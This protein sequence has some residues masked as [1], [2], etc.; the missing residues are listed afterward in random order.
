MTVGSMVLL[1]LAALVG[2]A[3]NSVAGGGSFVSFPSLVVS[4]VPLVT[5]N[6]T[7][8]VALWPGSASSVGAYRRE[9][10]QHSRGFVIVMG[11][12]SLVGGLL[13]A[14]LLLRT[15]QSTFANL[16]P[17]LLLLATVLFAF[18]GRIAEQLRTRGLIGGKPS[19]VGLGLILIFQFV[20]AV[21]GGY[22][23]GGIGILMLAALELIGIDNIHQ[24]NALK[25]VLATCT[26]GVAV[27][28]FVVAGI[29]AWPQA[30]V[31]IVA[32]MIGGYGCASFARRL[33][34]LFV[35]AFVIV[36]AVSMTLYFF[37]RAYLVAA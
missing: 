37:A 1:F 10:A 35:R 9:L 28:T 22:F 14:T 34:P 25:T 17:L 6:A 23:G 7:S 5:A 20:V 8:T 27:V 18:G 29:V 33:P 15:S 26:N 12:I 2:G 4:G 21:Y 32:A 11:V 30:I 36:V 31:M 3:I 13:G 16:I 24:A 19:P